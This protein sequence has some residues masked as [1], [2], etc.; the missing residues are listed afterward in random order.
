EHVK[1]YIFRIFRNKLLK[2][3][4][5]N[6]V[7]TLLPDDN[8]LE[9]EFIISHEDIIVELETKTKI[10]KIITTLLEDLTDKQREIIYLKFYCN[11]SNLEISESLSIEKQSVCNM[12]N[13]TFNTLREKLIK[14]NLLFFLICLAFCT[15][16]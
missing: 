7:N 12:L 13:R 5:K 2:P 16:K 1:A 14:N 3:S 6:T 15:I 11:L 4:N 9:K 8:K 10:S